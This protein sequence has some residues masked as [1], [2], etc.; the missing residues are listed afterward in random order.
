MISLLSL[1][2]TLFITI[3]GVATPLGLRES[4]VPTGMEEVPFTYQPDTSSSFG[5]ATTPRKEFALNRQCGYW[6]G[7]YP[8]HKLDIM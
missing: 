3:A 2:S 1:V 8:H 6:F 4:V 7:M 5:S